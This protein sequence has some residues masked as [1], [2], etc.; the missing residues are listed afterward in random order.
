M[1]D[2]KIARS[3]PKQKILDAAEVLI[4]ER[5]F[6][7]VTVRDITM[8]AETNVASVNYHFGDRENLVLLVISRMVDPVTD[9]RLARLEILE[10]KG[11]GKVV[12]LEDLLDA[13]VRPL[14]LNQHRSSLPEALRQ[15]LLGRVFS[16]PMEMW[17]EI[18]AERMRQ[19]MGRFMRAFGKTLPLVDAEE[20]VWRMHFVMGGMTQMLLHDVPSGKPGKAR[21]AGV[22]MDA[23]IGRFIRFAAAGLREGMPQDAVPPRGPQATFDF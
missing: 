22:G 17:P 12:R 4:A 21:S 11:L 7:A 8:R 20:L 18:S 15:R 3:L 13:M 2:E 16:L 6:E 19:M 5:G 9:E 14:G 1:K 10:R 23:I